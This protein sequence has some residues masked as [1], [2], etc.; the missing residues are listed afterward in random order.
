MWV[1]QGTIENYPTYHNGRLVD[2]IYIDPPF[3]T[4]RD[5]GEYSDKWESAKDCARSTFTNIVRSLE[6]LKP[7]GNLLI[8]VDYR[9]SHF[10]RAWIDDVWGMTFQNEI[11][12]KYNS[13]GASKRRLA[14]K[15]DTILWYS[16]TTDCYTFNEVR[17]PYPHKYTGEKFHPDGKLLSDVWTDISFLS[18]TSTERTGYPTQK[19][20]K[21]LERLI[22]IFSNE[23]DTVLDF[24]C[25]SGTT[26]VAAKN[27][28]RDAILFDINE[29][30]VAIAKQRIEEQNGI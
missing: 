22:Y 19:P 29:T 9:T 17:E 18:T 21:L 8:H 30:A 12:W 14:R 11:I 23:G 28:G 4:Q 26:G 24:Y 10:L 27:L 2:L 1:H 5:F 20:V 3:A 25:G 13:G 16:Y 6:F 7:S 15:H